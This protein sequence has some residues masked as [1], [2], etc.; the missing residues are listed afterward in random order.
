MPT[1]IIPLPAGA[2]RKTISALPTLAVEESGRKSAPPGQIEKII[3]QE[4]PQFRSSFYLSAGVGTFRTVQAFLCNRKVF[5]KTEVLRKSFEP[6]NRTFRRKTDV[7]LSP[8]F[9]DL[10]QNQTETPLNPG[11]SSTSVSGSDP[12]GEDA[13]PNLVIH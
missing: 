6:C 1:I 8:K 13:D 7:K 4:T 9:P 5:M 12:S 3:T 11:G 10:L 2:F